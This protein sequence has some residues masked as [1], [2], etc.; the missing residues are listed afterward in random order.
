[1]SPRRLFLCM[2]DFV[3]PKSIGRSHRHEH[4]QELIAN[5]QDARTHFINEV[6]RNDRIPG[7]RLQG[8]H[9]EIRIKGNGKR[10]SGISDCHR[11]MSFAHSFCAGSHFQFVFTKIQ[12]DICALFHGKERNTAYCLQQFPAGKFDTFL[13]IRRNYLPVVR[14]IAVNQ[15]AD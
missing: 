12:L 10:P 14:V 4:I 2:N 1:M 6:Q 8:S 15:F 11:F 7:H 3:P 5:L 9:E 13:A